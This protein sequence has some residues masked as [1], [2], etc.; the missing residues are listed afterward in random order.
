MELSS[1]FAGALPDSAALRPTTARR[2][3]RLLRPW[4]VQLI[5]RPLGVPLITI[6]EVIMITL[7]PYQRLS[8]YTLSIA[9]VFY[10]ISLFPAAFYA[11]FLLIAANGVISD[12]EPGLIPWKLTMLSLLVYPIGVIVCLLLA[13]YRYRREK[14][15]SA[16]I[17]ALLPLIEIPLSLVLGVIALVSISRIY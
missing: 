11:F 7:E 16:F 6:L 12:E 4:G 9:P 17:I 15:Q 2:S 3:R 5:S 10:F 13:W 14:F 1:G 8:K